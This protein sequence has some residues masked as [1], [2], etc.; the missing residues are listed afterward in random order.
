M[1]LIRARRTAMRKLLA[2]IAIALGALIAVAHADDQGMKKAPPAMPA[3]HAAMQSAQATELRGAMHKLWEDH[4]TYTR[5]FI[6]S[7]LGKLPD[8]KA[9]TNRLLQNQDDIGNA[10]KPY[11][12]DEAGTKLTAL[13][14]DHILI[15]A[16]VVKAAKS[17]NKKNLAKQQARWTA[18]GKDLAAFLSGANPNWSKADLET[19]L[20]KH[21]DLTT[22]EVVGRLTKDW[23][24]DIQS[25]DEGHA[26]M[27]MFA[28]MLTDGI[29]KQF[30]DKFR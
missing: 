30:P 5:N 13:L 11:Y 25:Y 9:V 29:V 7:A 18:N 14:R 2:P 28:D 1:H 21:L 20:Q 27:L 10:I 16:D 6:I 22:G 26:H 8:Q 4:I 17:G 15:A 19:M 23:D 24:K 3:S 12:G